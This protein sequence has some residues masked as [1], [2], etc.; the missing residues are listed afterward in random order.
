MEVLRMRTGLSYLSFQDLT[1][2]FKNVFLAL[3]R[4]LG[5]S[6]VGRYTERLWVRSLLGVCTGGSQSMFL[7]HV[8][9]CFPP[10]LSLKQYK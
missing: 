8:D 10:S 2:G 4:W 5:R 9:V 1:W 7:F 3:A 6:V